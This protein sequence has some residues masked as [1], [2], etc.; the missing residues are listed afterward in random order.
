MPL[1][2]GHIYLLN[3]AQSHCEEL[4]ILLCSLPSDPIKGEVRLG[5]LK[6]QFPEAHVV[7]HPKPL[8]RDQSNPQF[9]ELWRSSIREYCP[10]EDFDVVFSSEPYGKRLA[11]ELNSPHH[12]E[13]DVPR[14]RFPV[15]GTDIRR[16]PTA[17]WEFIPE[18]VRPY[19]QH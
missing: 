4:T 11:R 12:V 15:S 7:H 13:V 14:Q 9:W 19:Y 16:D 6:A 8:P 17:Y 1:H 10:E 3:T 2:A 5:W 18:S